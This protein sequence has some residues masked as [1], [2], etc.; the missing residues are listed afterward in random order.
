[1]PSQL[2]SPELSALAN[3][4]THA[5]RGCRFIDKAG[6]MNEFRSL[7]HVVLGA[8]IQ[9]T[10]FV[11]RLPT[12]TPCTLVNQHIMAPTIFIVPGLWE[13]P[14][15]F[16]PLAAALEARSFRTFISCLK[17]TGSRAPHN[18]TMDDDIKHL[19]H[20]LEMAIREAG[21]EGVMVLA[22]SAGGF[23]VS[24]AMDGLAASHHRE[25]GKCGGVFM[26]VFLAAGIAPEG[27]EQ[28]G[29]PF[30]VDKVRQSR[31]GI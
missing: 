28:F 22:H 3:L 30:A 11:L 10:H 15:S 9:I 4:I 31:E 27:T 7:S 25:Q 20:D 29:G 23:L 8:F 5:P 14:A 24:N 16:E 19:R 18:P 17:S 26:I 21:S 12:I 1:M 13:G 6:W 2:H